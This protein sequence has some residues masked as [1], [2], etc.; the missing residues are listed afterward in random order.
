M[1]PT[2]TSHHHRSTTKADHKPFKARHSTKSALRDRAK[3]KVEE[4]DRGKRRTPHQQVM[5]KFARKNQARQ[6]L[7]HQHKKK[8]DADRIFHGRDGAPKHV[9]V[10]PLSAN[11][12]IRAAV[13]QLNDSVEVA[14]EVSH[15]GVI[16]AKVD[17]FRRNLLYIP[18]GQDVLGA[19]DACR[20]ADFV[21]LLQAANEPVDEA[22]DMLIRAIEGQG[23]SNVLAVA[24]GVEDSASKKRPQL[25]ASLKTALNHYFPSL[26]KVHSL[27]NKSDCANLVRTLCTSATKGVRWRDGRSWMLIEDV[28]WP[29]EIDGPSETAIIT[30]IVRG[31]PMSPDRLVHIPSWGDHQ[32]GSISIIP[33]QK[34]PLKGDDRDT[35]EI[36]PTVE[37]GPT[38]DQDDMAAIAPEEVVMAD[39]GAVHDLAER[40]GVLLDDHHYFSDDNSHIPEQPKKLPKGTSSYQAAWY[41]DDVS[42]SGSAVTDEEEEDQDGNVAMD[43]NSATAPEDGVSLWNQNAEEGM[44]EA[45]PSEYPQSE[46]FLDP[47]PDDEAAE[48]EE[49]RASRKQEVAEDLEFPDEIEL[50]PNVVARERLA[51]YRGLKSLRTSEWVTEEDRLHEPGDWNRLLHIANYKQ[52][53]NLALRGALVGP[54]PPG[55][56]VSIHLHNVPSTLRRTSP[57][58]SSLFSLLR[59]EHKSTVV[60]ISFTLSASAPGPIK[61]KDELLLQIGA[62]RLLINPI[63]SS[64]GKTPNDV[65]KFDRYLHPG[66]TAVATFIG[67]LTWGSVPGLIFKSQHVTGSTSMP[68]ASRLQLIG[69]ATTNPTPPTLSRVVAKRVILTGH[70]Y[71]IH[72]KLVTVRYMFFDAEDVNWFKALQL[73]TKRGRT[74]FIKESLGT[75]GYFKATFDGKINPQDAVGISLYKR[76]F[77]RWAK[78][79]NG[80]WSEKEDAPVDDLTVS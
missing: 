14:D 58:P 65:H 13:Q 52:S 74:G 26:D 75:H 9:A 80:N 54:I 38:A 6:K 8:E 67:P 10:L 4:G 73:W 2:S 62:R 46:M 39:Y 79:W 33:Q 32:I 43:A 70:P 1:A 7:I 34:G 15:E 42:E 19:L 45:G 17:R 51:R 21:I 36:E 18:V 11:V 35:M 68:D 30:G 24:Q 5:S 76:V 63:F 59:H 37:F 69:T 40:K 3:G 55:T 47:S 28:N 72:K 23:I 50:H 29:Q 66:R 53:K 27:E 12:D 31:K 71:K 61:S 78:E 57:N 77:P 44:T 64:L 49:Y 41:L 56:R 25:L 48:L 60:N 16:R 20:L 22:G